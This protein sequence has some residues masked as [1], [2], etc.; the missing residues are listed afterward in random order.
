MHD[1]HTAAAAALTK[2]L[3]CTDNKSLCAP[4]H[5]QL[6]TDHLA[7]FLVSTLPLFVQAAQP[8]AGSKKA[9]P[10]RSPSLLL[11]MTLFSLQAMAAGG[12]YDQLGGGFHRYR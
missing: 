10:A 3:P 2:M 9:A 6:L 7:G 12:M 11:G 5:A 8:S 1:Q 4:Q